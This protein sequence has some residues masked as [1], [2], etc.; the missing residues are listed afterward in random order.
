MHALLTTLF[1]VAEDFLLVPLVLLVGVS[2]DFFGVLLIGVPTDFFG[3]LL[4]GVFTDFFGLIFVGVPTD[5]FGLI[6]VGVPT[7]FLGVLLL[8]FFLALGIFFFYEDFKMIFLQFVHKIEI[9][10]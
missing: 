8:E 2:T 5:F 10:L 7:D 6:L 9:Q 3:V 1:G 4:V